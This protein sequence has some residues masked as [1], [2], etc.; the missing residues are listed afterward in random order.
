MVFSLANKNNQKNKRMNVLE[1]LLERNASIYPSRSALAKKLEGNEKLKIYLGLDPSSPKIHLGN[2]IALR[3]LAEFQNLGHK[4]ILLVGDFTGKIGDPTDRAAA[5]QPLTTEQVLEN[6]KTYK[7][8]AEKILNFSGKNPAEIAY[9][10]EWLSKLNFEDIV[11]L[12]SHFTV[13][14]LLERDMFQERL[15]NNKPISLHEFLYPLMQGYDSVALDVDLEVGGTDQT[16][17]MLMGRELMKELMNKE[18]FVL[19]LPL[20]EGSDGR[21]MSKSFNNS[22]D[23]D[24]SPEDMFG[25]LMGVKDDLIVKYFELGTN[26]NSQEIRKIK[27]SLH[28][29]KP[30]EFKKKLAFE[31]TKLYHDEKGAKKAQ[32]QFE[33][34][35]QKKEV[36]ENL[37]EVKFS[38]SVLPK[39]YLYFLVETNLVASSSEAV[40]LAKQGG[41]ESDGKKIFDIR[42]NLETD[43]ESV[44]IKAGK[45]N[46]IKLKFV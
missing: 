3:K 13:Q 43:K 41:V 19:T 46:F 12:A 17:N 18:K 30:I 29:E 6:S 5:R 1:E 27:N 20:L 38:K 39:P 15:K 14:Q 42:Q 28:K 45:R 24:D 37:E 34:V 9:N 35:V 23:I 40:R 21:K 36:P 7:K 10:S 33:S 8:Q 22:I 25:K 26:L 4:I 32:E 2:A 16:F 11:K 31:I 44:I